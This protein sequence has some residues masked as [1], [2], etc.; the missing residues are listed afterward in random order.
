MQLIKETNIP[1]LHYRWIAGT[2]S[3]V[4]VLASL[5]A[6]LLRPGLNLGIDFVGGTQVTLKFVQAPDLGRMRGVLEALEGDAVVQRFDEP[7]KHELLIRLE[8]TGEEGDFSARILELL[9]AEYNA[10]LGDGAFDLNRQGSDEL[11]T[12]LRDAD[13][14]GIGGDPEVRAEHYGPMAEA[15]LAYRKTVG[16]FLTADDLEQV[17]GLSQSVRSHL[18]Q[19]TVAGEY[20]LLG[21]ESVGP[22]VGK[23]LR[24]KAWQAIIFS[25]LGMLVYIWI[26]FQLPYGVGAVVALFHDVIITLGALSLTQREISIPTIAALL[27][28]V[29]YSV[30]DTVV[31][32]DR[33]RENI[34]LSRSNNLVEL[35]NQSINQTLSRTLITSGTTALVV[36]S[37]YLFG[38]DVINTFAFVLLVGIVVGTY[39]SIFVAAPVALGMTSMLQ[40]M[41]AGR[42]VR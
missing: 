17:D 10:A 4:L 24:K 33:V 9:D 25:L 31:V 34:R 15:V 2:I 28:L 36:L 38:G 42:R 13:P 39:S 26:R 3:V 32:F 22:A 14:D 1:F 30:N 29:G 5:A 35:M 6:V 19:V 8:N 23:D 18:E 21:A 27:T 40:R 7:E 37:L 12:M 16:I 11:T 20:A 41:R